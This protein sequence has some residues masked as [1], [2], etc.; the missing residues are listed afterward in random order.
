MSFSVLIMVAIAF[1]FE[2]CIGTNNADFSS[3][4]N[5]TTNNKIIDIP[6]SLPSESAHNA[7]D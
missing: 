6:P 2:G 1:I 5:A 4:P 3:Q 7:I